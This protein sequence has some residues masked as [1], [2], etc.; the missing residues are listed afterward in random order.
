MRALIVAHD[1]TSPAGPVAD[2]LVERGYELVHHLVVP[3][4]R[5]DT[6]DV[7][8]PFPSFTDFD[9]VVVLGAP[10]SVYDD[11]T[12]GSWVKPELAELQ[13]ADEAGV[14]V[15]GICFG[16]Q[17]LAEAH[18]GSVQRASAPEI[19]WYSVS[20]ND[21]VLDGLWFEWHFD[22]FTPPPGAEVLATNDVAPQAF[23]LR[24]NLAVQFHPELTSASLQ[25]W[26]DNGGVEN[27]QGAGFDPELLVAWTAELDGANAARAHALVDAF[28]AL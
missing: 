15:L 20:S 17:L 1:H 13:A 7:D 6:P 2:R 26:L 24:R 5:Y 16:G 12:V 9:V 23:V 25:G 4:E 22:C 8:T 27:A 19:G 10:W 14:P 21:P 11:A 18:G 3:E 28:L